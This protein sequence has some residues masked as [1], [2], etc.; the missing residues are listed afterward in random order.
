MNRLHT[1]TAAAIVSCLAAAS[2]RAAISYAWTTDA[3]VY[4]IAPGGSQTVHLFLQETDA[5]STEGIAAEGGLL[6]VGFTVTSSGPGMIVSFA[7]NM[8]AFSD[9]TSKTLTPISA[10]FRGEIPFD[11]TVGPNPNADGRIDLGTISVTSIGPA[12]TTFTIGDFG[13]NA[14]TGT[15]NGT[16]VLD[17][18]IAAGS[19]TVA[20]PEPASVA[21]ITG[22]A[23]L[24]LR[25][26]RRRG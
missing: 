23:M 20:V 18:S 12:N 8:A 21:L 24:A 22:T 2:T 10:A 6:G 15:V 17:D 11:A 1:A 25:R 5:T 26:G 7:P 9:T 19:F 16:G 13:P 14:Q 3:P 4:T